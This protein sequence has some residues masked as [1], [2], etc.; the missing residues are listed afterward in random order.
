MGFSIDKKILKMLSKKSPSS[1]SSSSS[2]RRVGESYARLPVP[3]SPTAP[4][5]ERSRSVK[6]VYSSPTRQ[7]LQTQK[8]ALVA[9]TQE[10]DSEF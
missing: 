7:Y 9:I 3:P 6:F 2:L 10:A 5:V 4:N 8:L 1:S